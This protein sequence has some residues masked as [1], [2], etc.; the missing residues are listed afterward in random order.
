MTSVLQ[1]SESICLREDDLQGVLAFLRALQCVA[2]T[3]ISNVG[4]S[5]FLRLLA[6]PSVWIQEL[7]D[8]GRTFLPVYVDCNRMLEMTDQGFYELVLRCL[9][10]SSIELAENEELTAAYESLIAPTSEFQVPLS[11]NKGLNIALD[12]MPRRLVLLFD[13]FDEPFQQIDSRVFLNLRAKKDRYWD[14]LVY[15]TA[16]VHPLT[17]LRPGDHCGEFCELFLHQSW[18]LAPLKREDVRRLLRRPESESAHV[19]TDDD[20]DWVYLW[21]GGHPGMLIRIQAMLLAA[22]SETPDPGERWTVRRRL[23]EEVARDPVLI[24]ESAKIWRQCSDVEQEALRTLFAG[25]APNPAALQSLLNRSILVD[26]DGEV[27]AFSRLFADFLQNMTEM[28]HVP[29][30]SAR[31]WMDHDAGQVFVDGKPVETL[32]RLEYR[33]MT[34]LFE[35]A[36]RI[37][38]KYRLVSDVWGEDYIDRVDDARIEKLV[39]RLRQ[40]VE[41]N[42]SE[43][44]FIKTVRGRGY[45]LELEH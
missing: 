23:A 31:L 11:F 41:P 24:E 9:Q 42:P 44:Q 12:A 1:L 19:L 36:G 6:D 26:V 29:R 30:S 14:R 10:E 18:S 21:S 39:S 8:E 34:L 33:L 5:E 22:V 13:E 17:G 25:K 20:I 28:P 40:K 7:G 32:T 2:V 15:V 45:R 43:P 4:K 37:V 3:G 16:T 27:R 35:N 38:D